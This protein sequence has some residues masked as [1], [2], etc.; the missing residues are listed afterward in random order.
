MKYSYIR[1]N[2][3]GSRVRSPET[4]AKKLEMPFYTNSIPCISYN[5]LTLHNFQLS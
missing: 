4:V 3:L 1:V 2:L 5:L